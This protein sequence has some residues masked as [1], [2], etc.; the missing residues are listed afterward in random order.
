MRAIAVALPI[1]CV[2]VLVLVLVEIRQYRAGRHLITRRRF[3]LR[4]VAGGLMIALLAAI[5]VGVFVLRLYEATTSPTVFL[6]FWG[7]CVVVAIALVWAMF[8]DVQE[9]EDRLRTRQ[10]EMWRDFARFIAD[11]MGGARQGKK[12][13]P[14]DER[15]E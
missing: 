2:A 4:L 6:S 15:K 10:H 14:G 12:A 11:S 8:A 13:R 5:F 3:A 1:L 7:G 9:V